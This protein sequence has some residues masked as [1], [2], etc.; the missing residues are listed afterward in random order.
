MEKTMK[1]KK[2]DLGYADINEKYFI[3]E[4]EEEKWCVYEKNEN[5][6][7]SFIWKFKTLEEATK[8]VESTVD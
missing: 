5:N 7:L 4:M 3:Y 2:T 8:F 6:T 1:I